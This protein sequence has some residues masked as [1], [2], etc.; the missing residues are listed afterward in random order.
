MANRLAQGTVAPTTGVITHGIEV[1]PISRIE[2]HLG[3]QLATNASGFV[4]EANVHGNLW[5]GFENFLIGRSVNDAI[6][7]TQRICGVCP[8]PHGLT[9]TYAVDAAMGY[10]EGHITFAYDAV[11]GYG[12]PA[13]AV[14][15]RNLVLGAET[16]MSSI[17][18]FYHLVALDYVQGPALPP[19]TP[20]FNDG[21]YHALLTNPG[22]SV[23]GSAELGPRL[24]GSYSTGIW[25]AAITQY[26][27]ALRIR[28]L[29][30][31][32]GAL[33][34]GRMP[35]TS[36]FV[37]GGV[38]N[39]GTEDLGDRC[40]KFK[41]I[42]K[43]IGVFVIKEYVPIV[44]ALGALYPNYDNLY[45]ADTILNTNYAA[46][47][48][49]G[50]TA[51]SGSAT[52]VAGNTGWGA[53]VGNFLAW[54]AYP[55]PDDD[56]LA[57]YGGVYRKVG[58]MDFQAKTKGEI[59][60]NFITA[61]SA[62]A[63]AT[64][65]K[66]SIAYSHYDIS[67]FD[68]TNIDATSKL[69]YPGAVQRTKPNRA[70]GYSYIKSPRWDGLPCEV[71][72]L[73]RMVVR[74]LYK[75][76]QSEAL[77]TGFGTYY[78]NYTFNGTLAGG[79][80]PAMVH[81]DLAVAL[82]RDGLAYVEI[83]TG[84]NA[85]T[86]GS[87]HTSNG[88]ATSWLPGGWTADTEVHDGTTAIAGPSDATL[89]AVYAD[90]DARIR[91]P[92]A[93][94]I[95]LLRGGLSVM[96]RLRGRALESL[97]LV[98]QMIGIYT[99]GATGQARGAVDNGTWAATSWVDSLD[100]IADNTVGS[101]WRDKV[102]AVSATGVWGATE[103]PRG[104]L[105]HFVSTNEEGKISAYQCVVPTTWNASPRDVNGAT[106]RGPMEESMIGI[107][108]RVATKNIPSQN[109]TAHPGGITT[110]GGLE[111]LRVAHTYDPCIACAVH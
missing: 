17:T 78:T 7:F 73:A 18:H 44:L 70:N 60:S 41:T 77:A 57:I 68:T 80:D 21:F 39:D 110:Q 96:D 37:G 90:P 95:I 9:S 93:D 52:P 4:N 79:L 26:V 85:G 86:Y 101:T 72:P 10:S 40:S 25:D 64:N 6:T 91:G 47:W 56:S 23:A 82:L 48:T 107:P 45:N 75:V 88:V 67:S 59:K 111:A 32:A 22:G 69:G 71:G 36:C 28:R 8:V 62:H 12:I 61:T 15:I 50:N 24:T 66:E 51:D 55:N 27:K 87:S 54:G 63:M 46:L 33:F 3:V 102:P 109:P 100:A 35:M 99:K 42:M 43:E 2:G 20:F 94:W 58:G 105:A 81:A 30:F 108:Y 49:L 74:G 98:Q 11:S 76:D 38:T 16:L 65:L 104:A 83:T 31:E 5:R 34:A 106:A 103:A 13:K 29:T 14:H 53:G 84:A 19:W 1:D 97:F 92:V 89:H